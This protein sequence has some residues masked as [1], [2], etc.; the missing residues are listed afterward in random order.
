MRNR[1]KEAI[2]N[3][4]RPSAYSRPRASSAASLY[5]ILQAKVVSSSLRLTKLASQL[6]WCM[7]PNKRHPASA[8]L[9]HGHMRGNLD[10]RHP[11]MKPCVPKP[12]T[13][14]VVFRRLRQPGQQREPCITLRLA[15]THI[16]MIVALLSPAGSSYRHPWVGSSVRGHWP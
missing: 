5:C 16:S 8:V 14:T 3:I 9:F 1:L 7:K 12:L 13:P 11:V 15:A 2:L 6:S 10:S 4:T